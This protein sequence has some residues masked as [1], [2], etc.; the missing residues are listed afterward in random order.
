MVGFWIQNPFRLDQPSNMM[1]YLL[2]A[3]FMAA[4]VYY[5]M[6][7]VFFDVLIKRG[8]VTGIFLLSSMLH[9]GMLLAPVQRYVG[10]TSA[11]ASP[12]TLYGGS[13]LFMICWMAF[14]GRLNG[15]LDRHLF[16]R[17]DYRKAASEIGELMKQFVEPRA[18]DKGIV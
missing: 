7:F 1:W 13:I 12:L 2:P 18:R 14:Y 15:L 10:R 17:S 9:F 6:R 5:K 4:L 16:R 3:L 8:L 11:A